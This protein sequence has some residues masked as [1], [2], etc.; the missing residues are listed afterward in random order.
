MHSFIDYLQ[1]RDLRISAICLSN[2][3]DMKNSVSEV[4]YK[5]LL[6]CEKL[7]KFEN[8]INIKCESK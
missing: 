6:N 7:L 2:I 4:S 3:E 8:I 5:K 1:T